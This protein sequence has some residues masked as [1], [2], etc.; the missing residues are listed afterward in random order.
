MTTFA[1]I[2]AIESY[3][4]AAGD[5]A[6]IDI[7]EPIGKLA[8]E[9]ATTI[10]RRDPEACVVL[11]SS[12]PDTAQYRQLL[13]Q[14]P[15]RVLRTGASQQ[16]LQDALSALRGEGTLLVY[17]ISHGVMARGRRLLL[18]ADSR[19]ADLRA[20]DVDSLLT[21]LRGDAYPRTQMGFFD[22][23]AQVVPDPAVLS[24]GGSGDRDTE[25]YFYFS[26]AAAQV[27]SADTQTT[28]FSRT[29]VA[30]LSDGERAFPPPPAEL[31]AELGRR[32]DALQ[33]STRAFPLH[34]TTG[35]GT[36]W[37]SK[38]GADDAAT[39]RHAAAARCSAGEFE[40]L[41]VAAAGYIP[42]HVLCG[43]LRDG[44]M[45]LMLELLAR[46]ADDEVQLRGQLL[47]DAWGRLK[48]A[49]E[50]EEVCLGIG[51]S[52][53]EWQDLRDQVVA[54][55]N[56]PT[57]PPPDSL[58][59]LLCKLLDQ[60]KPQRGLDSC[61][62]L[63]ALAARRARRSGKG[64]A[65]GF[66]QAARAL[67]PLAGRWTRAVA[68]LPR[69]DSR[70]FLLI[71]LHHDGA[72]RTLSIV[73][74]WLYLDNDMDTGWH[75]AP[76]AGTLVEQVNELIQV[77]KVRH[78]ES[79]L[80]VELLAPNDLLCSPRALFEMTDSELGTCTWLEA[81]SIFILRWHDRMKGAAR[82][83]PGTWMQQ[84]DHIERCTANTPE[85]DIGWLG[86]PPQGHIVGIPFPGPAPDDLGRNRAAFFSALLQ[87][88]PW[89]C[90]PREVHDDE[91][92]FKQR[93]RAFVH[94]HGALWP[95]QP[96]RIAEALQQARSSGTDPLLCSLWLFI[97][98]PR[99][100]PYTWTYLETAQR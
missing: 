80:V 69:A 56:L 77:A 67:P 63:L 85:L 13:A 98:D 42:D 47:S 2:V 61:I 12:L 36:D 4:P 29:V 84:A 88:A 100:N 20:I 79:K 59:A 14:V 76:S 53:R 52:W 7:G 54:L 96:H 17:W 16:A 27:A 8:V 46:A 23:C 68:H 3:A 44:D 1:W 25:Q 49:R 32:F 19:I 40:Q 43:A 70:V 86:D 65:T 34:W 33:L 82:F 30:A 24:L 87:G 94:D 58:P 38:G 90:W 91:A 22:A 10:A 5:G 97:D 73:G 64:I 81:Q 99:R 35:S 28:G 6:S 66:E 48:L 31:F 92:A 45:E 57:T 74:S 72:S 9:L 50:I 51:L 95:G 11:S 26:A 75:V 39:A 55:D 89:M 71:G 78:A 15:D 83:Q 37:S 18:C 93:I 62:R 21:H 60:A 41:R